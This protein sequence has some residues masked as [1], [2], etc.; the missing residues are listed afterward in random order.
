MHIVYVIAAK[1]HVQEAEY[2]DQ[3]NDPLTYVFNGSEWDIK[4]RIPTHTLT[5]VLDNSPNRL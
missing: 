1:L 3:R 2:R 5:M 4:L